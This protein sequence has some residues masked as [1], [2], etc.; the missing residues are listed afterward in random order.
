MD[1][2]PRPTGLNPVI[3]ALRGWGL[4]LTVVGALVIGVISGL[5]LVF[6][7]DPVA[8][9][10]AMWVGAFGTENATAETLV[11]ATPILFV[12]I[13]VSLAFRSGV[14]NIGGEGQM[15]MGALAGTAVTLQIGE[16]LGGWVIPVGLVAG[17]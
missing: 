8:A 5:L 10:G 4:P 6:G 15:M 3:S 9:F 14:T 2:A 16:S 13:G 11:K 12:A 17:F 1:S 7:A